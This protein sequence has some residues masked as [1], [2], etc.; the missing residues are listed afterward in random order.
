MAASASDL[1]KKTGANTV[2]TLSAPGKALSATSI[3]VGSTTNYPT[4]TGIIIAIRQVDSTGE[5]VAGTYTEWSATVTSA[6]TLSIVA[7]PVYGSDQIYPA[8]S[9]TQVYIPLSAYAHNKLVDGFIA[10]HS[11]LDGT[12]T[13]I[14]A[15]SI[16]V[17]GSVEASEFIITGAGGDNGW[18][19][20]LPA[21]DTVTYNGNRSYDL[22]FNSTDLTDTVS[23]GMRLRTTRTVSAPTQCADLESGS[24]QYFSSASAGLAGVTFTDDFVVSAWVKLESYGAVSLVSRFNNTSGWDL[25]LNTAGSVELLGFNA[26]SANFSRVACYQSLPLNK[27]VHVAAQLDMSAFTA[28]TTT[29]YVM[30]DGVNVPAT[31]DRGGTNPTALVQ[32]GNLEIGSRNGGTAPFD[33][34]IAQVAIYSAKVT[35]ATI[36]ASMSQTLTGSET[37]LV[38]AYT[39]SND[40]TDLSA[41]NND[42]TANGG[43]LATNVDSPFGSYLGGTLDYGIITKTAFSTDTTLTVQVPE[44]CTIATGT[45]PLSAVAYSTQAVPYLFPRDTGRWEVVTFINAAQTQSSPTTGTWYNINSLQMS[46]PVGNWILGYD[47]SVSGVTSANTE[48]QTSLHTTAAAAGDKDLLAWIYSGNVTH[49]IAQI[50]RVKPVKLSSSTVYYFNSKVNGTTP[51]SLEISRTAFA[52]TVIKA[53]PAYL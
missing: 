6:T 9:T 2:T 38:S 45:T 53:T 20:G 32:A 44:G 51:T 33:G 15:D 23:E 10:E 27:W 42:L 17:T 1:I 40:I 36:T 22:V 19:S 4:D 52:I 16:V 39:L 47:A 46:V 49:L 50:S 48:L 5:L 18:S 11:Q 24:S 29:S 14:T 31:V 7:T 21:P 41:N 34:K 8:G 26:A 35:Q 30:L 13:D 37:S 25:R 12:H 43:A 3:T 28:T